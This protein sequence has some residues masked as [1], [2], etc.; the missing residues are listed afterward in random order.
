MSRRLRLCSVV[1]VKSVPVIAF[2]VVI[3]TL[4]RIYTLQ[5]FIEYLVLQKQQNLWQRFCTCKMHLSPVVA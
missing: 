4:V 5:L 3:I 2:N 1:T